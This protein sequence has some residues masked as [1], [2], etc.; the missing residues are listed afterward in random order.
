MERNPR[1]YTNHKITYKASFKCLNICV[2]KTDMT[3][4]KHAKES[5]TSGRL[6][7]AGGVDI[8]RHYN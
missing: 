1:Q 7:G 8:I 3:I 2:Y 6:C 4:D 5:A